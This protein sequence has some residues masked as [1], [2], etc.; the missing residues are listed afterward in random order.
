IR[1]RSWY[2]ALRTYLR[3]G[4]MAGPEVNRENTAFG[5]SRASAAGRQRGQPPAGEILLRIPDD[6]RGR[7]GS[8]RAPAC[9]ALLGDA[10]HPDPAAEA[11]RRAALLPTRGRGPAAP[12]S[13]AAVRRGL[14]DQGRAE[15]DARGCPQAA[16]GATRGRTA[17]RAGL[18][19]HGGAGRSTVR[20]AAPAAAVDPDRAGIAPRPAAGR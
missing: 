4:S 16:S 13:R 7:P 8:R 3:I 11:R 17:G 14:Y 12:D 19:C 1:A 10:L 5:R 2:F 6:Q 18:A 9:A 20:P 15:A